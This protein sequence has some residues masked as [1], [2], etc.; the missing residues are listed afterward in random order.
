MPTVV[1]L[2]GGHTPH[3]HDCWPL[4]LVLPADNTRDRTSHHRMTGDVTTGDSHP[5]SGAPQSLISCVS[6]FASVDTRH[7]RAL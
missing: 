2:H 3:E 5:D 6:A 1:H 4:D 7:D